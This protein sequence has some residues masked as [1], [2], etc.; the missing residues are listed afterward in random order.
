MIAYAGKR[1]PKAARNYFITELEM[2]GL[3]INIASFA[4]L[5]KREDFNAIVDHLALTHIIKSKVELATTRIKKLLEVLG[6]FSFNLYYI[7]G[8]DMILSDFLS[9]KR[10]DDSNPHKI[11][12]ISF[13]MQG[14]LQTRYYNLGKGNSVKYLVKT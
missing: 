1:L 8:R 3:A 13:H 7:K 10:H 11:I 5:L 2:C 12:P 6:S 14:I 4:H 9:R